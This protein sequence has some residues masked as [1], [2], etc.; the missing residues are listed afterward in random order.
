MKKRRRLLP[1]FGLRSI[2]VLTTL[3]A[4]ICGGWLRQ[5]QVQRD[6]CDRL[7]NVGIEVFLDKPA[8][9]LRGLPKSVLSMGGGHYFCPVTE[10][11]LDADTESPLRRNPR[12]N[13]LLVW[14]S[15]LSSLKRL[16]FNRLFVDSADFPL[17]EGCGLE[18]LDLSFLELVDE[19]ISRLPK[20]PKLRYL[21]LSGN[22]KLTGKHVD[23]QRF[24]SL[25]RLDCDYSELNDDSLHEIGRL[26]NLELLGLVETNVTDRGLAAI[27]MLKKL[28]NIHLAGTDVTGIGI[29][30]LHGLAS[31][32]L[33]NTDL[34]DDA[35]TEIAKLPNLTNLSFSGCVF[36]TDKGIS[37]LAHHGS[38]ESIV[39]SSCGITD[40]STEALSTIGSLEHLWLDDTYVRSIAALAAC[41]KLKWLSIS[42]Q[43]VPIEDVLLFSKHKECSIQIQDPSNER[44]QLSFLSRGCASEPIQYVT[45]TELASM[46]GETIGGNGDSLALH[47]LVGLSAKH[48]ENF[49]CDFDDVS[50][51]RSQVHGDVFK[52]LRNWSML[53]S[54]DATMCT[55]TEADLQAIGELRDLTSLE[56]GGT[57]ID[58]RGMRGI[59]TLSKL[60]KLSLGKTRITPQS[61]EVIK[62]FKRLRLLT[63]PF[64]P[65]A[66]FLIEV[67]EACPSLISI[68]VSIVGS[69]SNIQIQS[70]NALRLHNIELTTD[71]LDR[72]LGLHLQRASETSI[73][74]GQKLNDQHCASLANI[75]NITE[76]DLSGSNVTDVGIAHLAK[77]PELDTLNISDTSVTGVGLRSLQPKQLRMLVC[78][79]RT[80]SIDFVEALLEFKES[81]R[82]KHTF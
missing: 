81:Q 28:E 50:L 62:C 1:R 27:S 78:A 3:V 26:Q 23:Y 66:N 77:L 32:D 43:D 7:K 12:D 4:V 54:L 71:Q 49:G 22:L 80:W 46:A 56:L 48:L 24:P 34:V 79:P 35:F 30:A 15:K 39:A 76:L 41:K 55:V 58:D 21:N 68:E 44:E 37:A 25:K 51:A 45:S 18:E 61:L 16:E 75:S 70:Q 13:D 59:Q 73:V 47:G 69:D 60:R 5:A 52:F 29:G 38:L 74:A 8:F 19:D 82:A 20:L 40:A 72:L 10:I 33:S 9:W 36:L 17:L 14:V 42:S 57:E 63:L 11:E 31:V 64:I 2:L 67:L 6:V 65:D 53:R